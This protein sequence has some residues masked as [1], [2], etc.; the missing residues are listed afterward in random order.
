MVKPPAREAKAKVRKRRCFI[1]GRVP[2][3]SSQ[4]KAKSW[5][6]KAASAKTNLMIIAAGN[7]V[8]PVVALLGMVLGSVVLVSLVLVKARQSLLVG[9]FVCGVVLANT[10]L[11][12][13]LGDSP[14]EAITI[15]SELGIVL[16]MFTL[17]IEFSIRELMHLKKV[18][19]GGGG[20]QMGVTTLFAMTIGWAFGL[21][22]AGLLV[23]GF[24][25]ALSSTAVSIKSF[26]DIG[27]PDSPGARMALGVAIFQDIAV[28]FFM[29]VLPSLVGEGA[30]GFGPIL[31]ALGKGALFLGLCWVLS[32]YVVP[33]LLHAVATS[34]SRELFTVTV[35]AMCAVIAW[36]A[37]WFGLS[38]ALGAFA[39]GLVAVSY[40]HLTLPTTPYV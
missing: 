6:V 15:L 5:K 30:D 34:R 33:P 27:Q 12:S 19:F 8:A 22:G 1:S 39:G 23:V 13:F 16:L 35:V 17:G 2:R 7:E 4:V 9:Y 38:L 40:T 21:S 24:A 37:N 32:L 29:V 36:G 11:T 25:M 14:E 31:L 20:I 18:V 26:Q 3:F 28:I 10:G